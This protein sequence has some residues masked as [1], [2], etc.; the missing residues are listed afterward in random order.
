MCSDGVGSPAPEPAIQVALLA[1]HGSQRRA[2]TVMTMVDLPRALGAVSVFYCLAHWKKQKTMLSGR[3]VQERW[4]KVKYELEK[5]VCK[6]LP[7]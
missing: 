5:R 1:C 7:N 4:P 2:R 3:V 6:C